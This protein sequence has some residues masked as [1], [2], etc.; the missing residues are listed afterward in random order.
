MTKTR[1]VRVLLIN[2]SQWDML[3]KNTQY[4]SG[5]AADG[6][7]WTTVR[8]GEI[9]DF[10]SCEGDNSQ[11]GCTGCVTYDIGGT[12]V[13]IAFTCHEVTNRLGVGVGGDTA[14]NNMNEHDYEEFTEQIEESSG[15]ISLTFTCQCTAGP[16]NVCV[17]YVKG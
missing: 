15:S 5:R 2:Q 13:G 11:A 10:V 16:V 17:V 7:D 14:W 6:N 3:Y 1:K 8:R 12:E 4:T 9:G